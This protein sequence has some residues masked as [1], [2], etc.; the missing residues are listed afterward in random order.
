MGIVRVH[1]MMSIDGYTAGPNQTRDRPFGDRTDH[2]LDGGELI[3]RSKHPEAKGVLYLLHELEVGSDP[4]ATFE[5]ELD[6]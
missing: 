1:M 6:H 2:F 5:P 4:G 3:A